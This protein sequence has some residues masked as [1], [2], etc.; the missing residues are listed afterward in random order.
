M[1]DVVKGDYVFMFEL[2]HEGYFADGGTG[3]AFFAVK[4]DLF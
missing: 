2:F 4:M 3:C 1:D